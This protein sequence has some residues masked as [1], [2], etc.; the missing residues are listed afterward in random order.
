MKNR[1][2]PK[3]YMATQLSKRRKGGKVSRAAG[4][5]AQEGHLGEVECL[6]RD[7][8]FIHSWTFRDYGRPHKVRA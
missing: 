2:Y 1:V 7:R 6:V 8:D 5:N 4:S 3:M